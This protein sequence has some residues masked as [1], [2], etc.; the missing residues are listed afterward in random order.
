MPA[1]HPGSPS[2]FCA[3]APWCICLR[4]PRSWSGASSPRRASR[5]GLMRSFLGMSRLSLFKSTKSS[6]SSTS[7]AD[8]ASQRSSMT[9]DSSQVSYPGFAPT[10]RQTSYKP[11]STQG[12][13]SGYAE[14]LDDDNLAWGKPKQT[15]RR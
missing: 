1:R 10:Q 13:I 8:S 14:M 11:S 12:S 9:S 7:S 2:M 3:E 6:K 5:V 4:G 15:S